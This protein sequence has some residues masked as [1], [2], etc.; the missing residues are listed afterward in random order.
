MTTAGYSG[1]QLAAKSGYRAGADILLVSPP[2]EY[3]R[4]VEPL[5]DNLRFVAAP[6]PSTNGAH[7]FAGFAAELANA[8]VRLREALQPAA[9]IWISWPKKAAKVPPDITEHTIRRLALPMDFV[10]IKIRA[11]AEVRSVRRLVGRTE[12]R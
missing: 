8:L 11:V 7:I 5:P 10:E 6:T 9:F 3:L 4:W 1:K 2:D 12:L